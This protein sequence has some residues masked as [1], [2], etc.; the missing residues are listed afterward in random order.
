MTNNIVLLGSIAKAFGIK[1]ELIIKLINDESQAIK[2]GSVLYIRE[3]G[4]FRPLRVDAVCQNNR[5]QFKG[6]ADRNQALSLCGLDV[7]IE[8]NDLPELLDDEVYLME[9]IGFLVFL[10]D[11]TK[12]GE[13]CGFSSNNAQDLMDVLT[14]DGKHISIPFVEPIIVKIDSEKKEIV[15]DPPLGLLELADN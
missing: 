13:I 15:I 3:G 4:S 8:R 6:I 2:A 14:T 12:A 9:L 1:G 7:F 5:V 11:G 10:S